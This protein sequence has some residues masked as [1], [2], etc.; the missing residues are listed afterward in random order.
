MTKISRGVLGVNWPLVVLT[1]IAKDTC[2][3]R[4][5]FA[6]AAIPAHKMQK[7][8]GQK[9]ITFAQLTTLLFPVEINAEKCNSK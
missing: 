2:P 7:T 6:R 3:T 9:E 4:D 5:S 1:S 8:H